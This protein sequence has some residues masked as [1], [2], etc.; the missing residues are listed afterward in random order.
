MTDT[1]L[2]GLDPW[3]ESTPWQDS[4]LGTIATK[5]RDA[6]CR[7]DLFPSEIFFS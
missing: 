4:T 7:T 2:A 6:L 5:I 3:R 1:P